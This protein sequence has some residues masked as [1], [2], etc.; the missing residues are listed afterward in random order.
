[1][2]SEFE[3]E[4]AFRAYAEKVQADYPSLRL[5]EADTRAR[6][7]A[8]RRRRAATPPAISPSTVRSTR[9]DLSVVPGYSSLL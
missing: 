8:A 1:M 5:S 3:A 6:I 7:T 2:S 4:A 9:Y